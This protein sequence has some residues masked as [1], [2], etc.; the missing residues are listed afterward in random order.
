M[1]YDN[2]GDELYEEPEETWSGYAGSEYSMEDTWNA[3][4]DGAYGD[5]PDGWDGDLEFMGHKKTL[6]SDF[7]H[8][9]CV[10]KYLV[11]QYNLENLF[12]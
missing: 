5:M 3:V 9:F 10:C 6:G 2:N 7:F 4:T 1:Y 12:Q 8:Y 11:L